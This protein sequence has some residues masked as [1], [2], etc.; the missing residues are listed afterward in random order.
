MTPKEMAL[1]AAKALDEKKGG[2]IAAI[3]ITDPHDGRRV[4]AGRMISA[5]TKFISAL[6][7]GAAVPSGPLR[8]SAPAGG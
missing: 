5:P 3:E 2:D 8:G 6:P 1:T 7:V 4:Y